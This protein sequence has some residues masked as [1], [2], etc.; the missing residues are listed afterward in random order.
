MKKIIDL[1]V[2]SFGSKLRNPIILT[3]IISWLIYN[4]KALSYYFISNDNIK[5]KISTI[6]SSYSFSIWKPLIYAI[7]FILLIHLI[8][9]FIEKIQFFPK[10]WREKN[11]ANQELKKLE[12][13]ESILLKKVNIDFIKNNTN[14]FIELKK[15]NKKLTSEVE[16]LK[17]A[18]K[19]T[20]ELV[21]D[22]NYSLRFIEHSY[23]KFIDDKLHFKLKKQ[24][25][26]FK[27]TY[28]F[29]EFLSIL[30][31]FQQKK[32]EIISFNFSDI[33]SD[34]A[35][36]L[37]KEGIIILNS[38]QGIEYKIQITDKGYFFYKEYLFG[39]IDKIKY[40]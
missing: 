17:D 28:I 16:K 20:K 39:N 2:D 31:P 22:Y 4:W 11:K 13:Q 36:E 7:T 12:T 5:D 21:D 1:I 34:K 10:Y 33:N 9:Y 38:E 15:Q 14:E 32:E 19:L 27:N 25:D 29:N 30:K 35:R 24:Y 23:G 18:E 26:K 40:Y 8:M 6:E 37:E 3:Y